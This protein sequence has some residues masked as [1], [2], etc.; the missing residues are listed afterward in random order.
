M[1]AK[2]KVMAIIPKN[3]SQHSTAQLKRT[4]QVQQIKEVAAFCFGVIFLQL[5]LWSSSR[6]KKP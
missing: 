2:L 1:K 6:W 4:P 3:V 5:E